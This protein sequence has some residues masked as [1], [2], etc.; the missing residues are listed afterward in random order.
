MPYDRGIADTTDAQFA[1]RCH[2]LERETVRG[3]DNASHRV[4]VAQRLRTG[5]DFLH[6][7]FVGMVGC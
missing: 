6:H 4:F 7:Q 5:F 3:P 2:R 1:V